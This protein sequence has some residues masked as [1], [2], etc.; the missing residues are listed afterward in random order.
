MA[1]GA[2]GSTA[3]G[4][5]GGMAQGMF[6]AYGQ[7]RKNRY[8]YRDWRTQ[9]NFERMTLENYGGDPLLDRLFKN[10]MNPEMGYNPYEAERAGLEQIGGVAQRQ[11]RQGLQNLAALGIQGQAQDFVPA[12]VGFARNA[13]MDAL[14]RQIDET[15]AVQLPQQEMSTLGGLLGATSGKMATEIGVVS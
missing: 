15:A 12:S 11:Q 9:Q 5:V 1:W 7:Q 4:V 2:I 6:S 3:L 14:T 10:Q 13:Q 8:D